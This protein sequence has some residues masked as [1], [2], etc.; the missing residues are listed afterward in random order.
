M[1]E[2]DAANKKY[3]SGNFQGALIQYFD[4]WIKVLPYHIHALVP[5]D[6]LRTKLGLLETAIWSNISAAFLALARLDGGVVHL[7]RLG[8][9]TRMAGFCR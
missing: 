1:K 8:F 4:A 5:S 2:K 3:K 6:P 9:I 7:G